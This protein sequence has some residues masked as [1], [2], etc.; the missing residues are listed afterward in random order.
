MRGKLRWLG[1]AFIE[2]ITQAGKHILFD[3]WTQSQGND[4]CP[5]END[6]FAQTDLILVS[7]D[8]FDHIGSAASITNLSG[9]QLGGPDESMKRLIAEEGVSPTSVV[10]NGGGYLVGGG[11]ENSWI[12]VVTTPAHHTSQTSM[13]LGTI[14][15]FADGPTL[16]HAGDT[17]IVSEME[18][19]GRLYPIDIAFLPIFAPAM[20]DY[21]QATEA[22]RLLNPKKVM[23]IHFD[24]CQDPETE[25]E[26]FV[27]YC[28][29]KNPHVEVISTQKDVFYMV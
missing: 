25:L 8:H 6:A 19:F 28:Q 16:Y 17:S 18:I 3:P 1:V 11:F 9:A 14:A 23:P 21:V 26:R 13:P 20:M 5:Y 2:Y 22:V 27:H 10:N 29:Q 15:I 4:C 24:F 12:K 7:H